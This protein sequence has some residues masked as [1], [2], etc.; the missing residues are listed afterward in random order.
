MVDLA[1]K[2]LL[3]DKTRFAVTVMG[4][5]FAVALVFVQVGLF[6]GLI[7]NASVTIEQSAADLW[8]TARN[9]PNVDLASTFP[10]TYVQ[11]VRSV[12]GVA[13][14]DNLIV[15][16]VRV[17]LPTGATEDAVVYGLEDCVPLATALAGRGGRSPR[18]EAGQIRVPGR[19]GPQAVRRVS[20]RRLP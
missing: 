8:V 9:A 6:E 17:A 4:V 7:S 11:R 5:A 18:L 15:W 3:Y 1:R 12:P 14:A 19:L 10:E 13:R 16:V 20:G 2:L